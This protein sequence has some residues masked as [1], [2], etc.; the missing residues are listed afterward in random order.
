MGNT[1]QV[2]QISKKIGVRIGSHNGFIDVLLTTGIIGLL[3]LSYY[4]Y[5]IYKVSKKNKNEFAVLTL[6][7]FFAFLAM[8]F[9]QGHERITTNLLL[10]LSIAL[11]YN[12]NQLNSNK[13]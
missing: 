2:E 10:V 5:L 4:L 12:S 6:S 1:K 3:A 11:T 9:F 13:I 7:L 8:T